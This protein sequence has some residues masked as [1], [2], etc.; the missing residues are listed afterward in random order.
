MVRRAVVALMVGLV[1]C[2]I[3]VQ[4]PASQS[5]PDD[6]NPEPIERLVCPVR[7]PL[8]DV[9]PTCEI[10][11]DRVELVV[12]ND[13]EFP[14]EAVANIGLLAREYYIGPGRSQ[15]LIGDCADRVGWGVVSNSVRLFRSNGTVEASFNG[16]EYVRDIDFYCGTSLSLLVSFN[17]KDRVMNVESEAYFTGPYLDDGT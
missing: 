17:R 6:V 12:I 10:G 15:K 14:M 7:N 11:S 16:I 13:T 8:G 2:T 9:Q 5:V 1:G 4:E 3:V